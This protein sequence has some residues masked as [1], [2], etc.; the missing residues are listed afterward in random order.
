MAVPFV[1]SHRPERG[2]CGSATSSSFPSPIDNFRWTTALLPEL[3]NTGNARQ[4]HVRC[5]R[6]E[7]IFVASVIIELKIAVEQQQRHHEHSG[8]VIFD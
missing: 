1:Q 4:D 3:V 2:E 5:L 8:I 7:R 6:Q